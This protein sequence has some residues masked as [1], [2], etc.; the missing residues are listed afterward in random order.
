MRQGRGE[1][2]S[3]GTRRLMTRG[4]ALDL[5][6]RYLEV[7]DAAILEPVIGALAGETT[8]VSDLEP[9]L[10]LLTL[11][12]DRGLI[13]AE[14]V[15]AFVGRQRQGRQIEAEREGGSR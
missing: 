1:A 11:L 2:V 8:P 15:F 5:V 7:R 4:Q 6:E 12:S 13:D 9:F 14:E 10:R 3:Y